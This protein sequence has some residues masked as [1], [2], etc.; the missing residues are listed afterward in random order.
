M[1]ESLFYS[2]KDLIKINEE[3]E[4][5]EEKRGGREVEFYISPTGSVE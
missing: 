5:K 4:Q 1:Y 3:H 2:L